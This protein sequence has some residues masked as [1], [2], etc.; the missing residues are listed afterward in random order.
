MADDNTP[1]GQPT[2]PFGSPAGGPRSLFEISTG[3]FSNVSVR[4]VTN[5]V[6][7]QIFEK[8]NLAG[9]IGYKEDQF[10]DASALV[11]RTRQPWVLTCQ[12]WIEEGRYIIA[13]V[14]PKEVQW[15]MPQRS[16]VQ[17]TR[18][19]EILHIWRDRF[20]GTFY[21]E[22]TI[23]IAFQSGNIMPIRRDP[24][25]PSTK[26]K[27]KVGETTS[28][29]KK[30]FL[31]SNIDNAQKSLA[32]AEAGVNQKL[33]SAMTET[34]GGGAEPVTIPSL[35]VTPEDVSVPRGLSNFYDFLQLVDEQKIL[36]DGRLNYVYIIYNSRIFPNL[37][38]AG[39][40]TPDGVSW[41]DS[42]DDPN[43]VVGWSAN[44][45]IYDSFPALNDIGTLTRFFKEA[46]FGRV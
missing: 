2:L 43:Q 24:L 45:T 37:T 3:A 36:P 20:R 44:F 29:D 39:L 7:A 42:A 8:L 23:Q 35:E 21:D 4:D 11:N 25:R 33:N 26:K 13:N 6:G 15:R 16:V 38:L 9:E 34:F 5:L 30:P 41:S 28:T 14:N 46:G 18:V 32:G 27:K 19:G 12:K 1:K 22:P 10:T 31:Q 40:F 17:K